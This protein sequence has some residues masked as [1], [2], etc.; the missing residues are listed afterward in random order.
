MKKEKDR[1]D[2][3]TSGAKCES[4]GDV[5]NK[6]GEGKQNGKCHSRGE[7]RVR[8]VN[9]RLW[10]KTGNKSCPGLLREPVGKARCSPGCSTRHE[11]NEPSWQRGRRTRGVVRGK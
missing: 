4:R 3:I 9:R 8:G 1:K 7:L 5:G 11:L 10:G 6:M 2:K